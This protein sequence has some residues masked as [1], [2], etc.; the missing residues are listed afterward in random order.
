[1]KINL[2]SNSADAYAGAESDP[3]AFKDRKNSKV[4]DSFTLMYKGI[5]IY[6]RL[7]PYMWVYGHQD[8]LQPEKD[9]GF[10]LALTK[11]APNI[12]SLSI[13]FKGIGYLN[14][15]KD[16]WVDKATKELRKSNILKIL[17]QKDKAR[18]DSEIRSARLDSKIKKERDIR[19]K[20]ARKQG[21]RYKVLA[22]VNAGDESYHIEWYFANKP[23]DRAIESRMRLIG[24]LDFD[25]RVDK[26]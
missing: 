15:D 8:A 7:K 9:M 6:V 25:A 16:F 24:A 14:T 1:M 12:G 21:F 3:F 2:N 18:Q 26:L 23:T 5:P 22:L 19:N 11:D 10:T 4:P 20:A 17:F 13:D